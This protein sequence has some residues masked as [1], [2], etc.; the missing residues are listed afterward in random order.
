MIN[1]KNKCCFIVPYFGEFPNYFQLFLN[2]CAYNIDFNWLIITDSKQ[3]YRIPSNVLFKYMSF[4]DIQNLVKKKIDSGA[5]LDRP[6]K[7]CDYKPTYGYLFEE[8]IVNYQF[9]GHCDVDTLMGHLSDF[10]TEELLDNYDKL[11]CLG[12]MVLYRNT[13]ENNRFFMSKYKEKFPYKDVFSVNEIK[14]FDEDGYNDYNINQMFLSAGKPV[15]CED[16]SMNVCVYSTKF[17]RTFYK[18]LNEYPQTH[19]Y[20]IESYK[21][22]IYIWDHGDLVRYY[23]SEDGKYLKKE[24]FMYMHLQSRFMRIKDD[25]FKSSIIQIMPNKFVNFEGVDISIQSFY[26]VRKK[27]LN[28]HKIQQYYKFHIKKYFLMLKKK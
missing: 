22:A 2:T 3:K 20:G 4:E 21:E 6:Y 18:G 11:F 27:S 8:L 7:L 12:H 16:Y 19:G 9:W 14:V 13:H 26:K 23:I 24:S 5:V 17:K 1:K 10:I 25:I 28:F 15:F